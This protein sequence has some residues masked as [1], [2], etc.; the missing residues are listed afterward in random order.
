LVAGFADWLQIT[1]AHVLAPL[2]NIKAG[3]GLQVRTQGHGNEAALLRVTLTCRALGDIQHNR[4]RGALD[5]ASQ[6]ELLHSGQIMGKLVC[7]V[8][9]VERE[10]VNLEALKLVLRDG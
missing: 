2:S 1:A 4:R 3:N 10:L 9:I 5:L 6:V 7:F 8:K